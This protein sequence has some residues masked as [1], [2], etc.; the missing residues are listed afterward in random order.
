MSIEATRS[1]PLMMMSEGDLIS[2]L[3]G[4]TNATVAAMLLKNSQ[5][6]R[7]CLR[8]E[9]HAEEAQLSRFEE[10]QVTS[11]REKAEAQRDAGTAEAWGEIIGGG[12]TAVSGV[13]G[14]FEAKNAATMLDGVGKAAPGASKLF[15]A[16][17]NLRAGQAEADATQSEHMASEAKRRIDDIRDDDH[18]ARDL[19]KSAIDF[20]RDV[21]RTKSEGETAAVSIRA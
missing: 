19:L 12:F 14:A 2:E 20:L 13:A 6:D 16:D 10:A 3:G 9:R 1:T 17:A 7:E 8:E 18:D 11:L 21:N 15:A 4:D 5:Q